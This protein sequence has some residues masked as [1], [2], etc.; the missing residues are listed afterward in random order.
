MQLKAKSSSGVTVWH[1]ISKVA[2]AACL[3]LPWNQWE[4][5]P[6]RH[7]RKE[8]DA[9]KGTAHPAMRPQNSDESFECSQRLGSGHWAKGGN[10]SAP[11]LLL[12]INPRDQRDSYGVHHDPSQIVKR[13]SAPLPMIAFPGLVRACISGGGRLSMEGRE[14]VYR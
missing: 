3:S 13:T 12:V 11:S 4:R 5:Y 1:K 2:V 8:D 14:E 10:E 6:I 7:P 9:V